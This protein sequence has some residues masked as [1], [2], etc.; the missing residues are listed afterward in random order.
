VVPDPR[1]KGEAMRWLAVAIVGTAMLA[2]E[3]EL[4]V[5]RDP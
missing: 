1:S 4:D 2:A 5:A 3:F